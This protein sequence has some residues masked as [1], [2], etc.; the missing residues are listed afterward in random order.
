M[1]H[2]D[3][4]AP[5]EERLLNAQAGAGDS[6]NR[7]HLADHMA[8]LPELKYHRVLKLRIQRSGYGSRERY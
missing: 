3:R 4:T 2:Y 5:P 1:Y 7:N 8:A 6:D